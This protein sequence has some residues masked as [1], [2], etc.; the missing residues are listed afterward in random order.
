MSRLIALTGP[1]GSGKTTIARELETRGYVRV[2]FA[3]PLKAM[4]R[5]LGLSEAQVDGDA[6]SEPTEL[7]CGKTPRHAMQTLGEQWGRTWIG[8]DVWIRATM[9]TVD[10]L[11]EAGR[12]VVIDDCRYDNEALAVRERAG[13]VVALARNGAGI[14]G[15]H[16]SEQGVAQHL[17]SAHAYNNDT[18]PAAVADFILDTLELN[19]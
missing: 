10:D 17:V 1:A 8:R 5:A 12:D 3:G 18:N 14:E 4:L 15:A 11:L 16:G 13:A 9:R 6:K 2:R 19:S 7:L